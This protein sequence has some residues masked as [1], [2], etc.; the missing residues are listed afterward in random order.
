MHFWWPS[1]LQSERYKAMV[2]KG[3]CAIR[4]VAAVPVKLL[5]SSAGNQLPVRS[6]LQSDIPIWMA[7]E[8]WV[9]QIEVSL[10]MLA[11]NPEQLTRTR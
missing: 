5:K 9:H 8:K 6:G 3:L 11:D 10:N 1:G 4:I 7:K 2:E